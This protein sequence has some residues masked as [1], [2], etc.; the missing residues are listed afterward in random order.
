MSE[1]EFE[2]LLD[3]IDDLEERVEALESD[4]EESDDEETDDKNDSE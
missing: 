2:S 3:R 1:E 4:D